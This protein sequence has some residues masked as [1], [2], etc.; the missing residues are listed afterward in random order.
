MAS[1]LKVDELRGIAAAGDITITS[2]GGSATMQLQQGVAKAWVDLD[3]TGTISISDALN[4]SS[5]SD[6]G[7]GHYQFNFS[8]SMS[9]A[10]YAT[11]TSVDRGGSLLDFNSQ[12]YQV[13]SGSF[14]IVNWAN[15]STRDEAYV[16][17]AVLG[18]LA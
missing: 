2:E 15:S 9:S 10:N 1:I 14:K 18:D 12:P 3:G 16:I 7:V 8:S 17:G 6:I 4:I 13:I 5:T 11:L